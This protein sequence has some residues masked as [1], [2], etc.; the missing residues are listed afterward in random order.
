MKRL[1]SLLHVL[2]LASLILTA[3][4]TP[5]PERIVETV[6]VE[7]QVTQIV[8]G[9]PIVVTATPAPAEPTSAPETEPTPEPAAGGTLIV[10]RSADVVSWDPKYTNDNNSLWAQVQIYA[11]LIQN[12]P[13]GQELRPWLAESYDIS[14][15]ATEFTFKLR[16]AAFCD[17]SPITADDVKFSFERALEEDS[18]VSWQYP[19]SPQVEAVDAKT[20]KITL[21]KSN[22]AFPSYLTLWGTNIISKAYAESH[23]ATALAEQPLGSGPYC[24][25]SWEKGQLIILKRNPGYWDQDHVYPDEVQ[26]KVITDD[27]ARMLQLQTGEIDIALDVPYSQLG[28]LNRFPGVQA[29]VTPLYGSASIAMNQHKVEAFTDIKFRQ[30]LQYAIDRQAM[31]D[32]VLFGYGQPQDSVFYGPGLL[33][34]TPRY[35]ISY[36]LEKAKQLLS[37]SSFPNGLQTDL[38]IQAGDTQAAQTAV[39]LQAQLAELGVEF[40]IT[41]VEHGT[42]W[43][44]WSGG[45]FEMVYRLGTNDVIDPSENLPFDYWSPEEG[46]SDGGFTGFHDADLVRLSQEAEAE[47]DP[48]KRAALYDEFQMKAMEASH[49][50]WLFYPSNR[51][52]T[53]DNVYGFSVFSTGVQRF[54]EAW[55]VE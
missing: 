54:W 55:K 13:D 16:D 15:D 26:L 44:R 17:G 24:L 20:V 8:A 37:E 38:L 29:H 48:T 10:G 27:T 28:A 33:F 34:Y 49:I 35:G 30:A 47:L 21:A 7:V 46:G 25:D 3:C 39:V 42:W 31:V 45:D 18:S 32:A 6:Q 51:W 50:L 53:R 5:T 40:T 41:P 9:T 12:S 14:P 36:D 11:N 22:V 43:E 1:F 52:A 23:D 4:A 19:A 2:A